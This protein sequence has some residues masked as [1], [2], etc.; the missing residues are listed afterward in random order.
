MNSIPEV[1]HRIRKK[2]HSVSE[3][4][5]K[6]WSARAMSGQALEHEQLLRILEAGRWAPSSS[7]LQGWK[8]LYAHRDTPAFDQFFSL[9]LPGNQE[10]CH[11]AAVLLLILADT[12]RPNGKT[13][14]FY[15][16]DAG[17]LS[18]NILLQISEMGLVGHAV[19]GFN[20][21]LAREKLFIPDRYLPQCMIAIGHYGDPANL[22]EANLE[23]E[24]PN[25]R[26][27]LEEIIHQGG[28]NPAG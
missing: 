23:L 24:K 14:R 28:F 8:I 12:L 7:N 9:L 6:R 21:Q 26:K 19:A 16:F 22:S 3:I 10:W 27:P 25:Q 11:R 5:V 4:F 15:S 20:G 2:E 18:E 17:L 13:A 1:S